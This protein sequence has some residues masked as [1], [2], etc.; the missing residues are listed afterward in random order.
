MHIS[1]FSRRRGL[2]LAW[3]GA[4]DALYVAG[5]GTDS[6]L[7]IKNA[8]QASIAASGRI[9]VARGSDRCGPDGLAVDGA[10]RVLVWCSFTR[11]VERLDFNQPHGTGKVS[12]GPEPPLA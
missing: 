7:M 1:T 8:S 11:S 2:A 12:S 9:S 10:G 6:V 3:D 4:H 5:L